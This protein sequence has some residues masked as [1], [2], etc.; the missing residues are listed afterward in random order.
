MGANHRYDLVKD[1]DDGKDEPQ[2]LPPPPASVSWWKILV[3]ILAL[4]ASAGVGATLA[5]VLR[6]FP[7]ESSGNTA[8]AD[9]GASSSTSAAGVPLPT[10]PVDS[11]EAKV[12]EDP[13]SLTGQILDCGYNP[14]EARAKGCVYDVM[15]QDWVP[16]PCYDPILTERYLAQGNWTWYADAEGKVI[17]TD[18]E[19]RKGE[20]GSA[21]MSSSYHQAHCIFSW[22]KT[23]RALRNNRPIS[24]ELLSYD[25][26]LHCSHQTL[27]G[28][29]V[30]E[31][32]GV[33]APTNYA[34]CALYDTWK[35][36]WI[37]DRHSSTTD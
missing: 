26:V 1:H 25:H 5:I 22:D 15:M 3:G 10:R 21:W 20:H 16:E 30:D 35:Y 18:E 29:E 13:D 17:L 24:Q 31:S 34:K 37:P 2:P 36:N 14:E 32:I 33:R 23:V 19:M 12:E 6:P 8:V 11:V 4:L 9:M 27:N 7:Q 28:A